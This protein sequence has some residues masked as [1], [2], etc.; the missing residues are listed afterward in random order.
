MSDRAAGSEQYNEVCRERFDRI[1]KALDAAVSKM[2]EVKVLISGNGEPGINERLRTVEAQRAEDK[3]SRDDN[4]KSI[5]RIFW[6]GIGSIA[7]LII[8]YIWNRL[9]MGG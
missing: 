9:T 6:T 3:A 5:R 7:V 2:D 4:R 1:D 8:T